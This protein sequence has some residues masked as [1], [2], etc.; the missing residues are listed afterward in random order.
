MGVSEQTGWSQKRIAVW[1]IAALLAVAWVGSNFVK[2]FRPAD[3]MV[4]DFAQEWLSVK[5]YLAGEPV[6]GDQT[7][8]L[9]RHTGLAPL[10]PETML[11]RNAHPPV[12]ILTALPF[13]FLPLPDAQLAWN[14]CGFALFLLTLALIIRELEIPFSPYSLLPATVLILLCHPIHQ[15]LRQGQL[16]FLLLFLISAA[17]AADRRGYEVGAGALVGT[18]AAIKLFPAFLL[19]YF[20]VRGRWRVL[21]A[22]AAAAFAWNLL[23]LGLFGVGAVTEYMTKVVPGLSHY[24][25]IWWNHSP[26]GFWRRL[27]DPQP[28]V[29]ITPLLRSPELAAALVWATRLVVTGLVAYLCYRAKTRQAADRAFAAAIVGLCLVTPLTWHHYSLLLVMP[30]GLVWRDLPRGVLRWGFFVVIVFL[31]APDMILTTLFLTRGTNLDEYIPSASP[32]SPVRNL[33][34]VSF[35]VYIF[36]AL[37]VL[38]LLTP[39]DP[40]TPDHRLSSARTDDAEHHPKS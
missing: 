18:A 3:G 12:S 21:L 4:M 39:P 35:Q 9:L 29:N 32:L 15:Q 25:T 26:T 7:E 5:N 16:N 14:I 28:H 30:V 24:E 19:L 38:V 22:G 23:A 37:F 33:L 31:W 17:W 8:A 36:V 27:F 1:A 13:G 6:Y 34:I 10:R 20:L 2:S 40:D 11:P